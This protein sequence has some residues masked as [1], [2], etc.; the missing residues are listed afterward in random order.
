M[1]AHEQQKLLKRDKKEIV[2]AAI[3]PMPESFKKPFDYPIDKVIR[4]DQHP[5]LREYVKLPSTS[6]TE[7]DPEYQLYPTVRAMV[8]IRDEIELKKQSVALQLNGN[9]PVVS[10]TYQLGVTKTGSGAMINT[11]D[12]PT[13]LLPGNF[14][15][16]TIDQM[17]PTNLSD[18][19][20][21]RR[22]TLVQN[23]VCDDRIWEVP[24][25]L[26]NALH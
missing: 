12:V 24:E 23:F 1:Q 25:L 22:S 2:S 18:V 20:R 16:R 11:L 26:D 14:G 5:T 7:V 17:M 19:H 21:D 15:V 13:N 3:V 8:P 4:S 6:S 10:A 9:P